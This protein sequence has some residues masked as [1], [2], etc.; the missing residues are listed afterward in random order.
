VNDVQWEIPER[1]KDSTDFRAAW[2][3]F[4]AEME[5]RGKDG[6]EEEKIRQRKRL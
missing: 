1:K 2:K 4:F 5:K 6:K 3:A